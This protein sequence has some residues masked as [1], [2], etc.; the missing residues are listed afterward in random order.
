M[1]KNDDRKHVHDLAVFA[2]N[3]LST[4]EYDGHTDPGATVTQISDLAHRMG[5]A[6]TRFIE[7]KRTDAGRTFADTWYGPSSEDEEAPRVGDHI[8][9]D[10]H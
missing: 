10:L 3:V 2:L 1:G 6:R 4:L 8:E 5:F 9:R 7:F